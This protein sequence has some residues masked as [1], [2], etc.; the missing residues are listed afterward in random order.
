MTMNVHI[1]KAA[2][3][4]GSQTA[5]AK[6]CGVKQPYI[7]N[8]IHRD[9]ALPLERAFQIERATNGQVTAKQ[10]RPDILGKKADQAA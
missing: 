3:I 6:A 1:K 8:W 2:E 4:C 5:L 10:L 7:W 9:K